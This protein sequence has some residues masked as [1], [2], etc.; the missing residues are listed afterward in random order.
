MSAPLTPRQR[1]HLKSLAHAL[2]PVVLVGSDGLTPSLVSAVDRALCDH[3]LIKVRLGQ[4]FVDPRKPA[5]G[6]LA[7]AA[8]AAL[9]QIIGRVVT[10]Y[11][12]RDPKDPRKLPSI[13]LP[14]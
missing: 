7:E 1:A 13:R 6:K 10:L 8:E 9:V 2:Q 14:S 3:E 11:R 4:G 5:A 12:R